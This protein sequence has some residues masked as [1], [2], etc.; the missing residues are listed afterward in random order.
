MKKIFIVL[1]SLLFL[2]GIVSAAIVEVKEVNADVVECVEMVDQADQVVSFE[3]TQAEGQIDAANFYYEIVKNDLITMD[4]RYIEMVNN[5]VSTK[6]ERAAH[7]NQ[8]AM[9]QETGVYFDQMS[10]KG[11]VLKV[12]LDNALNFDEY[13]YNIVGKPMLSAGALKIPSFDNIAMNNFTLNKSNCAINNT[14]NT[15]NECLRC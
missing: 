3:I 14:K 9:V 2:Y 13:G 7:Y 15:G 6:I 12:K 1:L 10:Q 5:E 4:D 11:S 8:N